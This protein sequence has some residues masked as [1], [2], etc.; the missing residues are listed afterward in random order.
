[1]RKSKHLEE[2]ESGGTIVEGAQKV[3]KVIVAVK[4]ETE[5]AETR[6]LW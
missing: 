5:G 3:G 2:Q 6:A 4:Q 1:M